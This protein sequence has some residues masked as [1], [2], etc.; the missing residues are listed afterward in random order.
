MRRRVSRRAFVFCAGL[1][2]M[3]V[4]AHAAARSEA[5][6]PLPSASAAD[7]REVRARDADATPSGRSAASDL[8]AAWNAQKSYAIPAAEIVGFEFLLNEFDRHVLGTD[9]ASNASTIRRN[10]HS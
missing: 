8:P 7:K 1:A 4:A 10:L 6:E 9:F 5:P 3:P 2:V